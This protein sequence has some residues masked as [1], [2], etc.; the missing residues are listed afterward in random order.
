MGSIFSRGNFNFISIF[1]LT[2]ATH[3]T[4]SLKLSG[5]WRTECVNTIFFLAS[6]LCL[7]KRFF[8]KVRQSKA[9]S[10]TIQHTISLKHVENRWS[11]LALRTSLCSRYARDIHVFVYITKNKSSNN[12]HLFFQL[13]IKSLPDLN[14]KVYN[15]LNRLKLLSLSLAISYYYSL[16]A[17]SNSVA[18]LLIP[19]YSTTAGFCKYIFERIYFS[20]LF[21]TLEFSP[22]E[23]F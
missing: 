12:H 18:I 5:K 13:H 10:F 3:Y 23:S 22:R 11:V 19:T 4:I 6:L 16:P 8:I 7:Q 17:S 2:T 20:M 9:L 14:S 1:S 21:P 15:T